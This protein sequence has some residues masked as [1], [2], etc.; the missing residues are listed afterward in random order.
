MPDRKVLEENRV[1]QKQCAELQEQNERLQNEMLSTKEDSLQ[2]A[3]RLMAVSAESHSNRAYAE[4][5]KQQL[6]SELGRAVEERNKHEHLHNLYRLLQE[7]KD[8]L[9]RNQAS[10]SQENAELR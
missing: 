8:D 5:L 1:L 9:L 2:V 10:K 7:E 3:N 6:E 4:K